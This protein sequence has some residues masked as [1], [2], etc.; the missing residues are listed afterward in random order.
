M[1]DQ[2]WVRMITLLLK[3]K[4]TRPRS[5]IWTYRAQLQSTALLSRSNRSEA[6]VMRLFR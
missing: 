5:L 4:P 1:T 3:W 2:R 6:H